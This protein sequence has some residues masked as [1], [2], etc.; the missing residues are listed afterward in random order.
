MECNNACYFGKGRKR[1]IFLPDGESN[2]GHGG[3]RVG[4]KPLDYLGIHYM[5][6]FGILLYRVLQCFFP[7]TEI[8][9][10]K[11]SCEHILFY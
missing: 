4:P 8:C 2:P 3:E 1:K 5:L 7:N 6:V 10:N 9:L 11:T